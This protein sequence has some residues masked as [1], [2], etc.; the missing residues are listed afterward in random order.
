MKTREE[1]IALLTKAKPELE[2]KYMLKTMALFGSYARNEQN[3]DSDVDILV[4]VD[5]AI[6]LNFV[7]LAD[8]IEALLELPTEI[9][10][11]RAI[12]PRAY[13]YIEQDLLYV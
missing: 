12:K 8:K 11:R 2:Q 10:S 13:K 3:D 7:S 6:G 4:E 9:V 5:P 1:V